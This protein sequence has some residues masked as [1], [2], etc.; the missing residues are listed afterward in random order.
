LPPRSLRTISRASTTLVRDDRSRAISSSSS[1]GLS[2][3]MITLRT[4]PRDAMAQPRTSRRSP[5]VAAAAMGM[6]ATS[7]SSSAT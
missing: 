4:G 1:I 7:A 5:M 2:A 3:A 6:S